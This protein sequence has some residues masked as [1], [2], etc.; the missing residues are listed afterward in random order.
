M[1]S[2]FLVSAPFNYLRNLYIETE[3][4]ANKSIFPNDYVIFSTIA[5]LNC[6]LG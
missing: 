2:Q 1:L 5:S 6:P 4:R 3:G